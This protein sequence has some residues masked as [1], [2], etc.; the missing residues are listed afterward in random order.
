MPHDQVVILATG[1]QGEPTSALVRIANREHQDIEIVPGDTV[2]I[3]ASPIPGNETLVSRTI[4]NL[5]RQGATVLYSRIALVHVHGHGSREE[6]QKMLSL[7]RPKFF[8]PVHGE[9]RHLV[10]HA[11]IAQ[12]T[13]VAPDNTFVLE[14]G[15][16]L[17][18]TADGGKVVDRVPAGNVFV[19]GHRL[20]DGRSAVLQER[21]KLARGGVVVVAI[22]VNRKSGKA[23]APVEVMSSGFVELDGSGELL[24]RTAQ[25]AQATLDRRTKHGLDWEQKKAGVVESVSKFLYDETGMRPTVL[26]HIKEV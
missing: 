25:K 9:Y 13:G 5:Y 10:A 23:Q 3:S 12:S 8:V 20:W 26:A 11:A 4:D 19:D 2:V 7:V 16:V 24:K 15:D 22:T 14:D 1:A 6:L 17:E 21:R 18:L